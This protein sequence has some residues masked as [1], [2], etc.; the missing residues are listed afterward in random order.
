MHPIIIVMRATFD[1]FIYF[2]IPYRL[3][4]IK[5]NEKEIALETQARYNALKDRESGKPTK[6]CCV[7]IKKGKKKNKKKKKNR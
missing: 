5:K 1:Y 7:V 3:N 6:C 2:S 4:R